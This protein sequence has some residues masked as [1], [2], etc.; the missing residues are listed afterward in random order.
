MCPLLTETKLVHSTMYSQNTPDSYLQS[1]EGK[2]VWKASHRLVKRSDME[3]MLSNV[4]KPEAT[5]LTHV[6][7]LT[8]DKVFL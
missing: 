7:S 6:G 3:L 5:C 4:V 1:T 2:P 8:D